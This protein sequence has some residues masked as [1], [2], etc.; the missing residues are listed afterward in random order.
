MASPPVPGVLLSQK[1]T[2]H[3][4]LRACIEVTIRAVYH[5]SNLRDAWSIGVRVQWSSAQAVEEK[6]RFDLFVV[7]A[8]DISPIFSI[9]NRKRAS[10]SVTCASCASSES[11]RRPIVPEI[12]RNLVVLLLRK[13]GDFQC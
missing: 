13:L 4:F 7:R 6:S 3:S 1:S 2:H 8:P 9:V 10:V 5:G 12:A 11:T